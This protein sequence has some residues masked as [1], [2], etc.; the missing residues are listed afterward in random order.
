MDLRIFNSL[1]QLI[2]SDYYNDSENITI[3][4][5]HLPVGFYFL[6]LSTDGA[7]HSIKMIKAL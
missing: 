7:I 6:K 1:G 3:R 4:T 5:D 2:F